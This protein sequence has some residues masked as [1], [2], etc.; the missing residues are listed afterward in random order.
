[1]TAKPTSDTRPGVPIEREEVAFPLHERP[2]HAADVV[3][4]AVDD[5]RRSVSGAGRKALLPVESFAIPLGIAGLAGAWKA[6]TIALGAPDWCNAV[7][8][9]CSGIAWFALLG[10]YTRQIVSRRRSLWT[11]LDNPQT[12]PFM[13]FAPVAATL[14]AAHYSQYSLTIGRCFCGVLV[15]VLALLAARWF[16]RWITAGETLQTLHPGYLVPLGP[17]GFVS[18]IAFSAVKAHHLAI[19]AFGVGAFFWLVMTAVVTVRL[20][21]GRQ[22]PVPAIPT[23][24]SLLVAAATANLAWFVSHPGP[25]ADPQYL[26]TGVLA[27]MLLVQF[28]LLKVYRKLRFSLAF[29]T[30]SFPAAVTANYSVRW[31]SASGIAEHTVWAWTVLAVATAFIATITARSLANNSRRRIPLHRGP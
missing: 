26:L 20:M 5:D 29:W 9:A 22:L 19:A 30:F 17:A 1:M 10:T 18:S 7:L 24:S 13:A 31:F 27:M 2:Q 14:L 28:F 6:A 23:L 15:G 16:S 3:E 8:Y 4:A 21:A 12:G 11:D 25:V